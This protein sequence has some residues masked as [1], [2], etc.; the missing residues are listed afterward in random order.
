MSQIGLAQLAN[1]SQEHDP[2]QPARLHAEYVAEHSKECSAATSP[3]RA[4]MSFLVMPIGV[5]S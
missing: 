3:E 4:D 5:N 1:K 2:C